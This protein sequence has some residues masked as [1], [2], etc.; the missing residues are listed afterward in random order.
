[1]ALCNK[2]EA[3]TLDLGDDQSRYL[4]YKMKLR[5][6]QSAAISMLCLSCVVALHAA[7]LNESAIL[8]TWAAK[9]TPPYTIHY[10][11]ANAVLGQANVT[12]VVRQVGLLQLVDCTVD[13]STH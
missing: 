6:E 1:M 11:L 13:H 8:V 7:P 9:G 5:S 4:L 2:P 3:F 12:S 10:W